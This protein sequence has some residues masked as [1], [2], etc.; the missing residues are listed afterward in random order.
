LKPQ[1]EGLILEL[2]TELK[3]TGYQADALVEAIVLSEA[4]QMQGS[5][6]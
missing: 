2:L 4:F 1:D 6:L 3:R 5:S